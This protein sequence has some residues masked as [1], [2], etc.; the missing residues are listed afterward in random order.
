M[1]TEK[2]IIF[3]TENGIKKQKEVSLPENCIG[4]HA[5]TCDYIDRVMNGNDNWDN[6]K[7][8]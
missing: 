1:T 4:D 2:A 6:Y 7:I 8:K 5:N 3:Y